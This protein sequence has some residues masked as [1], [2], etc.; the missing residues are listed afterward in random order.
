MIYPIIQKRHIFLSL[1]GLLVA[2]SIAA[3][4]AFGLNFGVDF[5]GG[6]LLEGKFSGYQPKIAEIQNS[7]SEININN[8]TVQPS[9]DSTYILRFKETDE[10]SHQAILAQLSNL[11]NQNVEG[12]SF[13]QLRLDLVGPSIGRELKSKSFNASIIVL[14]MIILYISFAFRRVSKPIS[15]WKFGVAAIIA[16]AHDVIIT[17]G[18][19]AVLGY[20]YHIEINT[21]FIAAILTVL[22]YSVSDTIVVFDR[23]RE[24]LPKSNEDFENTVNISV[25]QTVSRSIN[26]SVSAMLALLAILLFGGSTI[27]DFAL[28]LL[29][30]IFIGTYSSIFVASP[31]LVVWHN[32]MKRKRKEV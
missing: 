23:V 9:E 1:S 10:D 17:L 22:G 29:I 15:S 5:K 4:I 20:F 7:L 32:L 31:I 11:A 19:F 28:A 18:A 3:L 30:G 13:T 2:A 16:L 24:N 14:L 27:W 21:A 6:T 8:L 25:N 12:A 26:T